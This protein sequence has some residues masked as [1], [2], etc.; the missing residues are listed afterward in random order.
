[1]QQN[2]GGELC[3]GT[4]TRSRTQA[5]AS[6]PPPLHPPA[7]SH[8]VVGPRGQRRGIRPNLHEKLAP[9]FFSV[10]FPKDVGISTRRGARCACP[11][12][13]VRE[14]STTCDGGGISEA[15]G[16]LV[17]PEVARPATGEGISA[18][19]IVPHVFDC[20]WWFII[21]A[22]FGHSSGPGVSTRWSFL[23]HGVAERKRL[24]LGK[25]T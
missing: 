10:S 18:R 11:L 22:I 20:G 5:L 19:L 16:S 13:R 15:D 17:F 6:R 21:D 9:F 8:S 23:N 4:A 1:M 3:R 14:V 2:E 25:L 24:D 7:G 12:S